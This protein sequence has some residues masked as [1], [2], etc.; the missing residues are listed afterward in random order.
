[1]ENLRFRLTVCNQVSDLVAFVE[2]SQLTTD[3]GGCLHYDKVKWVQQ[4]IEVEAFHLALQNLSRELKGFT[5][6]FQDFEYPN[7]VASTESL[8]MEKHSDFERLQI[9]LSQAGDH[10]EGLLRRIKQSSSSTSL[11]DE[12]GSNGNSK[13][14]KN[15][16]VK[17]SR[18]KK[19]HRSS[20]SIQLINVISVE[21]FILQIDET[22][23]LFEQFWMKEKIS[24]EQC[25]RLRRFEHQFREIQ[26]K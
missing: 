13:I 24:L 17:I 26:V 21:R 25:L 3:L 20:G 9:D 2:P 14:T 8:I 22:T 7:D 16:D 23:R 5:E 12:Q 18:P 4:R 11:K 1:M 10:G 19:A 15:G 6:A